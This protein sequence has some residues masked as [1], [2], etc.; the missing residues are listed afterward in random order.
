PS[1]RRLWANVCNSVVERIKCVLGQALSG[2][3]VTI[4]RAASRV[5]L[6]GS[7]SKHLCHR[8]TC[9]SP[10]RAARV[11]IAPTAGAPARAIAHLTDLSEVDLDTPERL[12]GFD[13][14]SA[15]RRV[16]EVHVQCRG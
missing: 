2:F 4:P 10:K 13:L 3:H 16:A 14:V 11:L 9:G 15:E 6:A 12:R 1:K 5:R 7:I 8:E